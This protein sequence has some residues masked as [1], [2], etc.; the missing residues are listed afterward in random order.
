M[1]SQILCMIK[2]IYSYKNVH[3]KNRNTLDLLIRI[4]SK[5]SRR[6]IIHSIQYSQH[7]DILSNVI[8]FMLNIFILKCYQSDFLMCILNDEVVSNE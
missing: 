6:V 3:T 8:I 5:L 7:S 1:F 4:A 2:S